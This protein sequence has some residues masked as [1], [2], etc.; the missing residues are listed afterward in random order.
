MSSHSPAETLSA[1]DCS[2]ALRRVAGAQARELFLS[3][4]PPNEV[5]A[6][7]QQAAAVY[8]AIASVLEAEGGSFASVVSETLFLRSL[9]S[10]LAPVRAARHRV[11]AA[12]AAPS[13]QPITLEIEQPPLNRQASLEVA[14]HAVFPSGGGLQIDTIACES[15]CDC[16]E[17]ASV[18]ARRVTLGQEQR[19]FAGGLGGQG[20]D[21]YSQSFA[22]FV[23]AEDLL[24][25]A[26]MDFHDVVRTWIHIRDIERDYDALNRA[27]RAFFEARGVDPIPA[28]TGIG[29]GPVSPAHGICLSLHAIRA[30]N[31]P[32]RGV[33]TSPTLNEAPQ[34]GA[35]F[36]RGMRVVEANKIALHVSGTA[37]I[38]EAGRTAH[39]GDF[40]AQADRMLV[41]V[42][43]LLKGQGATFADVLSAITYVKHAADAA[44]LRQKFSEAGFEGFPNVLVAASVCRP[45]LLCETEVLAVRAHAADMPSGADQPIGTT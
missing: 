42:A 43:A 11:L 35:D 18:Q 31:P 3:C 4:Q 8:R 25:R 12:C 16:P 19:L 14:V 9:Q 40:E 22:M 20:E 21:A 13:E 33:M 34:Y 15:A 36:V 26:G 2:I 1:H 27:R 41:N 28:S 5:P 24:K 17:C 10:D 39:P 6:A 37:S 7:D 23:V 29:G 32:E 44:R 38:D 30:P 45:D